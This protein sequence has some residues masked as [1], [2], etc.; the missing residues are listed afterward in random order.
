MYSGHL[1]AGCEWPR[2]C[3]QAP[4]WSLWRSPDIP[5]CPSSSL[6]SPM[7][8]LSMTLSLS[9]TLNM[10]RRIVVRLHPPWLMT[11]SW[12]PSMIFNVF[13]TEIMTLTPTLTRIT[14]ANIIPA[15]PLTNDHLHVFSTNMCEIICI[16]LQYR[17]DVYVYV[18]IHL[19]SYAI[20]CWCV[21]WNFI[22]EG[23]HQCM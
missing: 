6:S 22:T 15:P 10:M 17:V 18:V 3:P 1:L 13:P 2:S 23:S 7:S 11:I 4:P 8:R 14:L 20:L 19:H 21:R 16:V 9:M 12:H 5:V